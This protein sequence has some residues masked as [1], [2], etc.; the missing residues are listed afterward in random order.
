MHL[1]TPACTTCRGPVN[2]PEEEEQPTTKR[3]K[4]FNTDAQLPGLIKE[5]SKNF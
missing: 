5:I 3:K 2:G 4:T 1:P